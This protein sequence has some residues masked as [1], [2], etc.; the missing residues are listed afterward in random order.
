MHVIIDYRHIR[1][2][3]GACQNF[4]LYDDVLFYRMN[5]NE[6]TKKRIDKFPSKFKVSFNS[7][8]K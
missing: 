1:G 4:P 8:E 5:E 2:I 6:T 3:V 7:L